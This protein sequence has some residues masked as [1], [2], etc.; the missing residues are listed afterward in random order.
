MN[1]EIINT[2]LFW[3]TE[4]KLMTV[5]ECEDYFISDKG[6]RLLCVTQNNEILG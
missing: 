1:Q 6:D 3:S 2:S 4:I 5:F